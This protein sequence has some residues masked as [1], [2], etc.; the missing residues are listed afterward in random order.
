MFVQKQ[1]TKNVDEIDGRTLSIVWDERFK[2]K[3]DQL[4]KKYV[5]IYLLF[6]I[7]PITRVD[8]LFVLI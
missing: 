4:R 8:N 7:Y 2:N 1:D 3:L 6:S 5:H